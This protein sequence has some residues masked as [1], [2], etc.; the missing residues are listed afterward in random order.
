MKEAE[1]KRLLESLR[2]LQEDDDKLLYPCPRCGRPMKTPA[3]S[4][5]ISKQANV[6]ICWECGLNEALQVAMG[7][8]M[9]PLA[10]WKTI[11]NFEG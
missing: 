6:Y 2:E 1:A 7:E 5:I 9:L 3:R 10:Q 11:T 4:N 8:S